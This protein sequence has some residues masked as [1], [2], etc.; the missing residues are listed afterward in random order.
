MN[1]ISLKNILRETSLEK[2][3]FE[4]FDVYVFILGKQDLVVAYMLFL[5]LF[6]CL[7]LCLCLFTTH[8]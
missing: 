1:F 6:L 7:N 2:K 4:R 8:V 5:S 3:I